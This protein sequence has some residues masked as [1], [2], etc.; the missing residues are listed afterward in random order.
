MLSLFGELRCTP[1]CQNDSAHCNLSVVSLLGHLHGLVR[2]SHT[3]RRL[4]TRLYDLSPVILI[5][6][7]VLRKQSTRPKLHQTA[8]KLVFPRNPKQ[9]VNILIKKKDCRKIEDEVFSHER[10]KP[11]FLVGESHDPSCKNKRKKQRRIQQYEQLHCSVGSREEINVCALAK[12]VAKWQSTP[13]LRRCEI[14]HPSAL[15]S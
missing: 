5:P 9:R 7:W 3:C 13:T 1:S 14:L 2:P 15:F 12:V 8:K 6:C 11:R 10:P 4:H